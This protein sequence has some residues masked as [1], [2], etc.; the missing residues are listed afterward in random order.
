MKYLCIKQP[1]SALIM[2]GIK[3][4]ENRRK[5]TK[6]RGRFVVVASSAYDVRARGMLVNSNLI[7]NGKKWSLT[8]GV[9][10]PKRVHL[11]HALGTVDLVDCLYNDSDSPW[12]EP[13][14]WHWVLAN[15]Q[16]FEAP[17]PF[18]AGRL[19]LFEGPEPDE[20]GLFKPHDGQTRRVDVRKEPS[21]IMVTRPGK[22]GNNWRVVKREGL[23]LVEN[24]DGTYWEDSFKSQKA[25]TLK[26]IG[27]FAWNLQQKRSEK[28][29]ADLPE[30][31]G[32]RLGC[33]CGENDPCHGD[34]WVKLVG[35]VCGG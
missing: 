24:P 4:I 27:L 26:A 31:H 8:R 32:K 28:L 22:W 21:D 12:A 18:V 13:G 10:S 14:Q 35:E 23:W 7:T 1:W 25:A 6:F 19:G 15:P 3:D 30:L 5:P 34:V 33:Y 29:M 20:T 2:S 9:W 16:P 11:R 17:V